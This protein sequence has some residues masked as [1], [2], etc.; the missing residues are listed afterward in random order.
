MSVCSQLKKVSRTHERLADL[1]SLLAVILFFATILVAVQYYGVIGNWIAKDM[2]LHLPLVVA[3]IVLDVLLI[4]IFLN[5]GSSRFTEEGE[6][7]SCF[8]TFQGR[9]TG[10]GGSLFSAFSHWVKHMEDV[11]KKQR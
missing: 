9:R 5:V 11:N 4:F 2:V 6:E 7:E 8:G 10:A 3:G 1:F